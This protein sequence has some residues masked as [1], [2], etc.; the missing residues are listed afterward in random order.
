MARVE[1]LRSLS[2]T[3][4]FLLSIALTVTMP[5]TNASAS[6]ETTSGT[7]TGTVNVATFDIDIV[8]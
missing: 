2:L 7:I 3:G 6:N 1:K 8:F 4:L 5:A